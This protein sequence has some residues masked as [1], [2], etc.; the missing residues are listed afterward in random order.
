VLDLLE[1]LALHDVAVLVAHL[2]QGPA[3]ALDAHAELDGDLEDLP[4]LVLVDVL[5]VVGPQLDLVDEP[6]LDVFDGH[7]A[8]LSVAGRGVWDGLRATHRT[9]F[10][11]ADG[12]FIDLPRI[13]PYPTHHSII[14]VRVPGWGDAGRNIR[15]GKRRAEGCGSRGRVRPG[16]AVVDQPVQL[17]RPADPLGDPP[18]APARR[19]PVRPHPPDSELPTT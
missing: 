2:D 10:A 4:L 16:A 15:W 17:H 1:D 19:R 9:S 8:L 7:G 18:Q 3:G 12:I 6:L 14:R 13:L 11:V 5:V